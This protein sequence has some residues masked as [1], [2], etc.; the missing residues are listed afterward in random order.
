M[1]ERK[2]AGTTSLTLM[3][4]LL[5]VFGVIAI[6]TPALA[7]KA[8]VFTIGIVLLLVGVAQIVS[9]LRTESLT[10][11]LSALIL[12]VIAALCGAGLLSEPL[13]GMEFIAL[14]LAI[15]FVAE[16][17]WKIIA[18]FSY[19]PASGWLL[20]LLSGIIAL[21]LG[22]MIWKQWPISGMWAVGILVGVDLLMTGV[23]M[24]V[25][26]ATIRRL[27]KLAGPG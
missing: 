2:L 22:L 9:G 13:V 20:F 15:F 12:G 27:K 26:A 7:G 11:R 4:I 5:I 16:G 17:I 6:A 24:L 3:G 18:S 25:L 21:V 14:L 8:V 10:S 19:R 1:A 23:S